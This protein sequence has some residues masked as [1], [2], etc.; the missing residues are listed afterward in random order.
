VQV[1][2]GNLYNIF[3]LFVE[4]LNS[5]IFVKENTFPHVLVLDSRAGL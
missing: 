5:A 2:R 3:A 1:T 4:L